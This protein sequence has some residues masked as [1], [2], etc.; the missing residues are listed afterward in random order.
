MLCQFRGNTFRLGSVF[1]SY[2]D[3]L[4]SNNLL[5]PLWESWTLSAPKCDTCAFEPYCGADPTY[6]HATA[7]NFLGHKT[8]SAFCQRNTGIFSHLLT[9]AADDS[10]ARQL[11]WKW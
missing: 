8:F 4:K 5:N 3:L 6:H 7:G 2:S 10:S 1:D 9:L 11:L